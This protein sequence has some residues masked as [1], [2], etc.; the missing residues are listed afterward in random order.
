[1]GESRASAYKGYL[2]LTDVTTIGDFDAFEFVAGTF[3][4]HANITLYGEESEDVA[5]L[6][7][8]DGSKYE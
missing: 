3:T 6:S 5:N 4:S 1:L 2:V 7:A 8:I